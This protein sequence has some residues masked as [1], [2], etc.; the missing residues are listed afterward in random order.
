MTT[1]DTGSPTLTSTYEG[2]GRMVENNAGGSYNE[3]VNVSQLAEPLKSGSDPILTKTK[4]DAI[5]ES[6]QR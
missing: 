2:L 5:V 3:F 1:V 6:V 4:S